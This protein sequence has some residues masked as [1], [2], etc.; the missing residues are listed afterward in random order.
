MTLR[1]YYK[2]IEERNLANRR[3]NED[4]NNKEFDQDNI[5]NFLASTDVKKFK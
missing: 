3:S 5:T 2:M 4:D 1:D